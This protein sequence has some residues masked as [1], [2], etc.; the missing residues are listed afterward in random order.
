MTTYKTLVIALFFFVIGLT[1]CAENYRYIPPTSEAGLKCVTQCLSIKNTCRERK[2][3]SDKIAKQQCER[4]SA[5]EYL[6]CKIRA[7]EEFAQCQEKRIWT[8][9]VA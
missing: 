8:I 1:G 9:M 4:R 6:D 2:L 3:E 7:E 5:D